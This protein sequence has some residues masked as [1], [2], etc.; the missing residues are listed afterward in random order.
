[1]KELRPRHQRRN[2]D[3]RGVDIV[4]LVD[5]I[6]LLLCFFVLLSMNMVYQRSMKVNLAEARTGES[7]KKNVETTVVSVR[8]D[9]SIYLDKAPVN[10]NQL[11]RRL[12]SLQARQDNLRV[13]I[14]ADGAAAHRDVVAAVDAVRKSGI[15]NVV[16]SVQPDS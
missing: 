15:Q 2:R 11:R 12:S 8:A 1:M 10:E 16:F 7:Q 13:R 5:V 4:P 9:G 6:F 3:S 14:H